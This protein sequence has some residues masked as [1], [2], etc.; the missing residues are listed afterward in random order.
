MPVLYSYDVQFRPHDI[1]K[2][3]ILQARQ[4]DLSSLKLFYDSGSQN[5]FSKEALT[6]VSLGKENVFVISS[7]WLQWKSY[8]SGDITKD[9]LLPATNSQE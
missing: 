4:A 1:K 5:Y 6:L 7:V 2:R 3:E 8:L 9:M